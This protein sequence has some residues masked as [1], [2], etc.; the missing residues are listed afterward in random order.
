[1]A[2]APTPS[3]VVVTASRA[4]DA[5]TNTQV[6][7]VDEGGIVKLSGETLVIPR[8]TVHRFE[9]RGAGDAAALAIVTPGILGPGYFRDAFTESGIILPLSALARSAGQSGQ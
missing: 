1:M 3:A 7:G 4:P 9:N 2:A 5:I 8:G 6:A